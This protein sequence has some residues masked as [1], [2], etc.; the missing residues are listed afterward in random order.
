MWVKMGVRK[1]VSADDVPA[2]TSHWGGQMYNSTFTS[3]SNGAWN[4]SVPVGHAA[5]LDNPFSL[6][7]ES[8]EMD[9][10]NELDQTGG[11][12]I[13]RLGWTFPEGNQAVANTPVSY[14][15]ITTNAK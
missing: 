13:K 1:M 11:D 15:A 4:P 9:T 10:E 6:C 14:W 7:Q 12:L 2:T 5:V 3:P 8:W